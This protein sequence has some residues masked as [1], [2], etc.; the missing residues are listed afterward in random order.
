LVKSSG[1]PLRS[2]MLG[3][4]TCSSSA[5]PV[6][7]NDH[8]S[9]GASPLRLSPPP[10]GGTLLAAEQR[11]LEGSRPR[12]LVCQESL[13]SRAYCKISCS[14]VLLRTVQLNSAEHHQALAQQASCCSCCGFCLI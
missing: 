14:M 6:T 11:W 4:S 12:V 1:S 2:L 9:R 10:W 13:T 3:C 8:R 7:A 5:A